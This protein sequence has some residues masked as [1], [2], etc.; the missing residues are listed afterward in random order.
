MASRS[1]PR[2]E[3]VGHH[4]RDHRELVSICFQV[5]YGNGGGNPAILIFGPIFHDTDAGGKAVLLVSLR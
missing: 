3:G 2:R 1:D 4:V 5:T